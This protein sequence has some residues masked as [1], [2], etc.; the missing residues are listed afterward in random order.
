M[1]PQAIL[2]GMM[3]LI[4]LR[5]HP[6]ATVAYDI[7]PGK[8][9]RDMIDEFGGKA[10]V[11]PVGH[12]L[13]KEQMIKQ[14][15]IF[16]GESS[17]HYFYKRPYGTFETPMILILKLLKFI[18]DS[19]KPFSEVVAPFKRYAH[20][21]EINIK[22]ASHDEIAAKIAQVKARYADGKQILIDGLTV[23]Y[24]DFWFN[25][26]G[27]NTEPLLRFTIEAKDPAT[28]AAKRDEVLALLSEKVPSA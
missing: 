7:R 24:P 10:V 12:S 17:G 11:T 1:I 6:G 22:V 21:G 28:M 19:G 5:E 26:R 14:G 16:G 3:A 27:S 25:L 15:A 18:S 20:S 13:I 9:T 8:I 2:R 4:E 23:E